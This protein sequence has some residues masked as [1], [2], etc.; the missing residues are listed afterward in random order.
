MDA[1]HPEHNDGTVYGGA[2]NETILHKF[3]IKNK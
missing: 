2:V 3:Y 1:V